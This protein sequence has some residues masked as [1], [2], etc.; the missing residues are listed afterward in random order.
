MT[1]PRSMPAQLK[2]GT[3]LA[4]I[5]VS[6]ALVIMVAAA[7][8]ER[9]GLS[10]A[11]IVIFKTLTSAWPAVLYLA[12][13]IGLGRLAK[14]LFRDSKDPLLVQGGVGVAAKL[15][16]SHLLGQLGLVSGTLSM[17]IAWVPVVAGLALLLHQ[18]T[19]PREPSDDTPPTR[20][21]MLDK[22]PVML[23]A[24][25]L[26]IASCNPP[27]GL[28]GMDYGA[29]WRSE[30]GGFD[31]L[32]YHL[33]VVQEW[34][35]ARKLVPVT[36]DVYSYLPGYVEAG[37][38][39]LA[40]MT[41]GA[42]AKHGLLA[43]DGWRLLTCQFLHAGFGVLSVLGTQRLVKAWLSGPAGSASTLAGALTLC[44]P[45][46]IVV[47]SLAYNELA[48]T[49]LSAPLLLVATDDKLAPWRRG[50]LAGL[51]LGAASSVKPPAFFLLGAPVAVLVFASLPPRRWL[52][53]VAAG[54]AAG[55]AVMLPWLLR[56]WLVCG[57]PVFP[58][59]HTM[60]GLAHWSEDQYLRYRTAH[61]ETAS[62]ADRVAMM[63]V[64]PEASDQ[65]RGLLHPQWALFF[66]AVLAGGLAAWLSPA[67][68]TLAVRLGLGL[69]AA[70]TLW[71]TLTHI[72]SRFLLP[73]LVPG[74]AL[75]ALGLASVASRA[76]GIARA[77]C[78][79]LGFTQAAALLQVFSTQNGGDP[80]A[81]LLHMPGDRSGETMRATIDKASSGERLVYFTQDASPLEFINLALPQGSVVYLLGEARP[82]YFTTPVLYNTVWD[83]WPLLEAMN[84]N[85]GD[86]ATQ[87]GVWLQS[88][89]AR[90]ATH[91]LLTVS[92]VARYHANGYSDPKLSVQTVADVFI[93]RVAVVR[94][95]G[96]PSSPSAILFSLGSPVVEHAR[97]DGSS[98][99]R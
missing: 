61:V 17:A 18:C 71:L 93:G 1:E 28:S 44:T 88:L 52:A 90:G 99:G 11:S 20:W 98:Y 81:D 73:L 83:R 26:V 27:G 92:E 89:R 56:N 87:A 49:A 24:A 64:R 45:W 12:G 63:F 95:W 86:S 32:S 48:V 54:C 65:H 46:A 8:S 82:L 13:A 91:V 9:H 75:A 94:T 51:L 85:P 43:D 47:G 29:L 3:P 76:P 55:L 60:F 31:A 35:A 77:L 2:V 10:A 39:H 62:L 15:T 40:I 53:F 50:A 30:F 33:P 37:F 70:L 36:H 84:K 96:D 68:R 38:L 41:G 58:F 59:A 78:V 42:D 66:P 4:Y 97:A 14:P 57:N 34:I 25:V 69:L 5:G 72:Q 6:L 79:I 19:G 23:A 67:T 80:G 74:A 16:L 7:S 21:A 22:L